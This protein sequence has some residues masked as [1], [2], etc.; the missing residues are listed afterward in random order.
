MIQTVMTVDDSDSIRLM[1]S[2]ILKKQGY[3]VIEATSGHDAL[4]KLLT[5]KP[6][7]LITDINMPDMDGISLISEI[8]KNKALNDVPILI[9]TTESQESLRKTAISAGVRGW[10]VKP[11]LNDQLISAVRRLI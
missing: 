4:H 3:H 1:L 6:D 11:V 10:I 5:V 9:L 8:K 7:L 2:F